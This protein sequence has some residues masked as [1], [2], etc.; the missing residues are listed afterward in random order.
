M[1]ELTGRRIL[2][3]EDEYMLAADVA[4][5]LESRGATVIG[6]F[7]SVA[8]AL[9]AV[10]R[11]T[12]DGAVLDINLGDERVYPVADALIGR[13]V[14][15]VFATGYEELLMQRPYLGLPRCPKPIDKME[16]LQT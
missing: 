9:A 15:I 4:Q 16:L 8:R 3:V 7:G 2:V 6:P 11:E 14:P 1:A 5:F 12:I 13:G 10:E